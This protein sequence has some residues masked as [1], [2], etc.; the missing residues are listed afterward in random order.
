MK[1]TPCRNIAFWMFALFGTLFLSHSALAMDRDGMMKDGKQ[2]E[3]TQGGPMSADEMIRK[4]DEMIAQG[5][6]M[7]N[8]GMTMKK[9]E[10]KNGGMMQEDKMM[11]DQKMNEMQ[12]MNK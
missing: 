2:G 8:K 3:M 10:M 4:G 7:K 12:E 1:T 11:K 6:E 5:K 9:K